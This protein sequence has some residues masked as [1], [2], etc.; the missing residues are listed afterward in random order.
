M[1]G[2]TTTLVDGQSDP[3]AMADG[4]QRAV[5]EQADGVVLVYINSQQIPAA[6]T[7]ARQANIPVVSILSGNEPSETGVSDDIGGTDETHALG[8]AQGNYVVAKSEGQAKVILFVDPSFTLNQAIADGF[9]EALAACTGCSI[10]E[11]V[12]FTGADVVTKLPQ[13][14]STAA[15]RSADVDWA[16]APYDAAATSISQGFRDAGKPDIKLVGTGG[17]LPNLKEIGDGGTEVASVGQ[18]LEWTAFTAMDN[19]ARLIAGE[20]VVPLSVPLKILDASNLPP[21][22]TAWTGDFDFAAMYTELWKG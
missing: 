6:V 15:T 10:V 11:E 18:A 21:A 20:D 12:T 3:N 1:L 4:V 14:A 8:S 2:W 9:K 16:V 17:N 5:R 13:L 7:A 19:V 22:G